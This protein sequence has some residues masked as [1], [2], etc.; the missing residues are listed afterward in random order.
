MT[1]GSVESQG[2][3]SAH[4]LEQHEPRG[5]QGPA[6][7][8]PP[9]VP[10]LRLQCPHGTMLLSCGRQ[11]LRFRACAFHRVLPFLSPESLAVDE[12]LSQLCSELQVTAGLTPGSE[13]LSYAGHTWLLA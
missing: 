12:T 2:S 5:Q 13:W 3:V 8:H 1:S 4:P 9:G 10:F 11:W 7:G 6:E